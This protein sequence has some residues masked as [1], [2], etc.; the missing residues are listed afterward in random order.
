MRHIR[1]YQPAWRFRRPILVSFMLALLLNAASGGAV[2]AVPNGL[3]VLNNRIYYGTNPVLIQGLNESGTEYTCVHGPAATPGPV[4]AASVQAIAQSGINT[5]RVPLNEDCW[6][7]INGVAV[8]G[9]AYQQAIS[10]WVQ[11]LTS[12]GLYVILDL[13]WSAPGSYLA[14]GQEPMA[15]LDHAPSFWASVAQTFKNNGRVLFELYNEPD[16]IPYN[17]SYPGGFT[18]WQNA[19]FACERDGCQTTATQG[20]QYQ[21][22]GMQDLVT[23][24]RQ[25]GAQNVLLVGGIQAAETVTQFLGDSD[26]PGA[27]L[28]QDPLGNL[29]VA[30]H[31]YPGDACATEACWNATIAPVA[32]RYPVVV[33]EYGETDCSGTL[34]ATLL[35]W[36]NTQGIGRVRWLWTPTP[37][38]TPPTPATANVW[39]LPLL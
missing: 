23:T 18:A 9:A 11:L 22:V 26:Q 37:A 19:D 24:I 28:P 15:D 8:G 20:A 12:A 7:G 34:S 6:L 13:H 10:A 30:T 16:P 14:A 5:I 36:L 27:Y 4:T 1:L 33:T 39:T 38:C 35:P 32:A 25:T 3:Y 31:I 17:P 29:A 2:R 21:T